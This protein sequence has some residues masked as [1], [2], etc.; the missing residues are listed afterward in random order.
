M[1]CNCLL[2]YFL[3]VV[4]VAAYTQ[5][6]SAQDRSQVQWISFSQLED[7]LNNKPKK[8]FIDFYT[9]W[10]TYCRK[11][12]KEVFTKPAVAEILNNQYYAVRM[13]AETMDTIRFDGRLYMNRASTKRRKGIHELAFL[14]GQRGG[15]F[16]PPTMLILDQGFT[17]KQRYFQY[18]HSKQ[19]LKALE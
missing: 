7:S 3:T 19:L 16:A 14:L 17:V 18:M 12:D 15:Q 13:D 4:L 9:S 1:I 8:V 5:L 2:K 11:M 10:C 6:A